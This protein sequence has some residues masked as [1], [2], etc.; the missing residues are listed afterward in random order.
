MVE[1]E[2]VADGLKLNT[3][4]LC[5]QQLEVEPPAIGQQL[6]EPVPAPPVGNLEVEGV[7]QLSEPRHG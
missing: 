5:E 1:P 4:Q 7:S 3:L 6:D 2:L